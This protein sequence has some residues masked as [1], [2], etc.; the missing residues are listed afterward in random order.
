M[1]PSLLFA[2][3]EFGLYFSTD[4]GRKWIKFDSLPVTAVRDMVFHRPEHDLVIATFGRGFWILDDYSLLR[5]IKPEALEQEAGLFPVKPASM[6]I[7]SSPLGLPGKGFQ[8]SAFYTAPNPPFGAIFTYYLKDD[9][10]SRKKQRQ[11]AEKKTLKEGGTLTYPSWEQLRAE[12]REVE[13]SMLLIVKDEEGN[14]VRRLTAPA[15]AGFHRVA[16]DLRFPASTPVQ[17]QSGPADLFGGPPVGP[18]AAPGKYTITLAKQVDDVVTP[19]GQPQPFEARPLFMSGLPA[20]DQ[21]SQLAFQRKTASL[22]R[23]VMGAAQALEEAQ[24]RLK[25]VQKAILETPKA[26][27]KLIQQARALDLRLQDIA[28]KL[29]GDPVIAGH[30]EPTPPAIVD[31]VQTVVSAHWST[32]AQATR[33]YEADYN[34]AAAEFA[35]VLAD[36]RQAIGV[37][38]KSLEDQL[39]TLGAPWTPGRLPSWKPE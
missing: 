19:V 38:L 32:T 25:Y 28:V 39:E 21:A 36:L 31:R 7:E 14:V 30:N 12:E 3:T 18:L 10:K 11:E 4:G 1:N 6:Y 26:D 5:T 20:Q 29:V 17:L 15:K 8:G 22:Q 23:A 24:N 34:I 2:G 16:W 13:P 27:L 33:T 37:D 9:L 35:P